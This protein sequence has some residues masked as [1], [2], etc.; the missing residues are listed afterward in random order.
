LYT[1]CTRFSTHRVY[2][3]CRL[4]NATDK[5]RGRLWLFYVHICIIIEVPENDQFSNLPFRVIT[6]IYKTLAG[7]LGSHKGSLLSG[8]SYPHPRK[9]L[10]PRPFRTIMRVFYF[11]VFCN[12]GKFRFGACPQE[13]K[14]IEVSNRQNWVRKR[15]SD[16]QVWH[17]IHRHVDKSK[18]RS[19]STL[20]LKINSVTLPS[21]HVLRVHL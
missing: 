3:E 7:A 19:F 16:R 8:P 2:S 6:V 1:V 17:A 10:R 20:W 14:K 15:T 4:L 11:V 5:W 18:F 9:R 21:K 12:W 13:R